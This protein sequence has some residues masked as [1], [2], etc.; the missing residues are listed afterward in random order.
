MSTGST[1]GPDWNTNAVAVA[2]FEG[3]GHPDLFVGNYFP[4]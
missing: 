3:N 4:D 1:H 2:D